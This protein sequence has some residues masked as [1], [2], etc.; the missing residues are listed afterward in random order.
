MYI[1]EQNI[2]NDISNRIMRTHYMCHVFLKVVIPCFSPLVSSSYMNPIAQNLVIIIN[3]VI[4]EYIPGN[5]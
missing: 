2:R 5:N 3:I 1:Q 4:P